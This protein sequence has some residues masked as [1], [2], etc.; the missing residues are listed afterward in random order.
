MLIDNLEWSRITKETNLCAYLWKN[1]KTVLIEVGRPSTNADSPI[2]WIT[3]MNIKEKV[4]WIPAFISLSASW[5][6]V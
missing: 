3:R 6:Q 5:V 1:I 4:N 2:S